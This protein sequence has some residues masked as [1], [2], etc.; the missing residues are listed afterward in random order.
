MTMTRALLIV[1]DLPRL[2]KARILGCV[3]SLLVEL[4]S[5]LA[6]CA[7]Y[8]AL[9]S[10]SLS[11]T[12]WTRSPSNAVHMPSCRSTGCTDATTDPTAR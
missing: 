7:L 8:T 2:M 11:S 1:Y 3:N 10:T 4:Q 6:T 5:V 12:K 9:Q